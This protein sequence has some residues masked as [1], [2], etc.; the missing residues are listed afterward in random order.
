MSIITR[1]ASRRAAFDF[2]C[3][4]KSLVATPLGDTT[5]IG[6]TPRHP[7][8]ERTMVGVTG[9]GQKA[10]YLVECSPSDVCNAMLNADV[11]RPK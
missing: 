3:P 11:K 2:D 8:L 5:T 10:A 1:A 7:G 4:E 6:R 9:C